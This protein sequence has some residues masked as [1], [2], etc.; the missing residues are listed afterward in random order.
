[1]TRLRG[2]PGYAEAKLQLRPGESRCGATKA[3]PLFFQRR[4]FPMWT[5]LTLGA[6]S[7]NTLRQALLIGIAYGVIAVPGFANA[8]D[9]LPVIGS[10]LP[11]AIL[12]FSSVSGQIAEKYETSMLFRRL[13]FAEVMLMSVTAIGFVLGFGPLVVAMLFAMGAQSA[14]FSPV[15]IAAMPKYLHAD[16]LVR[17][18]AFCS[19]GLFTS[20]LLGYFFGGLLIAR[21]HGGAMVGGLLIASSLTG[22]LAILRAPRAS[23]D[24]PD[25]AL[26]WNGAA[27]TLRMIGFA[28]SAPGVSRPISG[29]AIFYLMSTAITVLLPIYARDTLNADETVA[30][31]IMGLFAIGAGVGAM[32]ASM[33]SK[34]SNGLG[35]SAFGVAA[36]SLTSLAIVGLTGLIAVSPG[37]APV[38]ALDLARTP[39]GFA[40]AFMLWLSAVSMGLYIVPLQAAVQRRAPAAQ[41]A[42]IMAAG[43][44]L[45]AAAAIAGSLSVLWITRTDIKPEQAFFAVGAVQAAIAAYMLHRRRTTPEGLYDE[46]LNIPGA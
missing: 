40:L 30:T 44:M 33:L 29:V 3:R 28:Y 13:K 41:R 16:E 5:A 8:D 17:G 14:F 36:A 38:N 46:S 43:N 15:R 21:P 26:S 12:V 11:I 9:A 24:A 7:D 31:A 2:R 32:S 27:Q 42:R 45:N 19:G 22:W 37:A 6:F 18:N 25:L 20:I 35:F 34:K 23:A 39:T 1:M 4:F 10:F